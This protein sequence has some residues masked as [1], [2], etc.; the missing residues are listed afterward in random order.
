MGEITDPIKLTGKTTQY[1]YFLY[2]MRS[3]KQYLS[4]NFRMSFDN[5]TEALHMMTEEANDIY[6]TV[7]LPN[8]TFDV[9]VES[10]RVIIRFSEPLDL[11]SFDQTQAMRMIEGIL[12]TAA[13]FDKQVQFE[14]ILQEVWNG[15]YLLEPLPI[16]LGPNKTDL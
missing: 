7:I 8:V 11:Q 14:N 10:E 3:G 12:L 1:N 13:S 5:V 9:K 2:T 15:F 6:Q 16:P 4:P